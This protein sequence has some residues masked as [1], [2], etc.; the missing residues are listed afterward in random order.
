MK[1]E[2]DVLSLAQHANIVKCY[3]AEQTAE[4][5]NL[6]VLFLPLKTVSPF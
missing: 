4:F 3:G 6:W 5:F 2:Y 1:N